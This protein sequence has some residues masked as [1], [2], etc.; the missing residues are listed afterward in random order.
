MPK[1][2]EEYMMACGLKNALYSI[3]AADLTEDLFGNLVPCPFQVIL[4]GN[5]TFIVL[6]KV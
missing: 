3:K 1:E 5:L 6:K 4:K 2:A